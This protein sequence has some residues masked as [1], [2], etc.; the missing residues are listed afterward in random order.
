MA[1]PKIRT[2]AE[3]RRAKPPS[4]EPELEEIFQEEDYYEEFE[5]P[6]SMTEIAESLSIHVTLEAA[7]SSD[8]DVR[9]ENLSSLVEYEIRRQ[10]IQEAPLSYPASERVS[11]DVEASLSRAEA[12]PPEAELIHP[13]IGIIDQDIES[14]VLRPGALSEYDPNLIDIRWEAI[15]TRQTV[16]DTLDRIT[17]D[18]IGDRPTSLDVPTD[19]MT[20]GRIDMEMD[21]LSNRVHPQ[22][23]EVNSSMMSVGTLDLGMSFID[24]RVPTADDT[25]AVRNKEPEQLDATDPTIAVTRSEKT[26][27]DVDLIEQRSA[28]LDMEV[29][30]RD[31]RLANIDTD[32]DLR[33]L[34][35]E[36]IDGDVLLSQ[37]KVS[38]DAEFDTRDTR[39]ES[40][41]DDFDATTTRPAQVDLEP[42]LNMP[43]TQDVDQS[44]DSTIPRAV[45]ADDVDISNARL[46]YIADALRLD[47]HNVRSLGETDYVSNILATAQ[48]E[49]ISINDAALRLA[50]PDVE[51]AHVTGFHVDQDVGFGHIQPYNPDDYRGYSISDIPT[52]SDTGVE[53]PDTSAFI[54]VSAGE[55]PGYRDLI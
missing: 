24:P 3:F 17:R 7:R 14:N 10:L 25:V 36:R 31:D 55:P 40:V 5:P 41:S 44:I 54:E 26:D 33:N 49:S 52:I 27:V 23:M 1:R 51:L 22:D 29:S 6:P 18:T 19:I 50:S 2:P 16:F 4:E 45:G 12:P 20:T 15:I 48:V 43:R 37:P 46:D 11:L 21:A 30:L 42:G 47:V 34:T 8:P 32:I 53:D 13:R 35:A 38:V 9:T 39:V 28:S